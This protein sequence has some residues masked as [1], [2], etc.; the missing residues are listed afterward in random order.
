MFKCRRVLVN[1]IFAQEKWFKVGDFLNDNF[2][3]ILLRFPFYVYIW[4]PANTKY[5][6][7]KKI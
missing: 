6:Y 1:E 5:I 2:I 4:P 3:G 7:K